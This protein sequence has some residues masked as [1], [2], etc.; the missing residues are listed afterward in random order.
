MP[1]QVINGKEISQKILSEVKEVIQRENLQIKLGIIQVGQDPA[2]Q[3][4]VKNKLKRAK[5]VGIRTHHHIFESKSATKEGLLKIIRELN[6]DKKVTG[7]FIQTPIPEKLGLVELVSE[8]NPKKDVDGMNPCSLG[9]LLH[10]RRDV[11]VSATAVACYSILKYLNIELSGKH[12]VIAGRSLI[13]G[14]PL[15]ALLL[16]KDATVTICHTKTQN[17]KEVCKTAD[18]LIAATG[19][20]GLI[21]KSFVKKGA[22]VIDCGSPKPEVNEEVREVASYITPV[23]G[24][25]GPVT[26]ASLL[27]NCLKAKELQVPSAS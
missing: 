1:A 17:L 22:V 26:I 20:E 10:G 5:E 23:P 12:A 27:K 3:I 14:K 6:E 24:G 4:Y 19:K 16:N 8:I 18:I 7:F 2:T 13:L 11:L 21:T 9:A 25:V 15:A